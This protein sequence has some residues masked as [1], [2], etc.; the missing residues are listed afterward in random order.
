[1]QS[2][3]ERSGSGLPLHEFKCCAEVGM[4]CEQITFLT[5]RRR[6][7]VAPKGNLVKD[8]GKLWTGRKVCLNARSKDDEV[9][10][11]GANVGFDCRDACLRREPISMRNWHATRNFQ[12]CGNAK[13]YLGL[14]V[15]E[16]PP[17]CGA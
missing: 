4:S 7:S 16:A 10:C 9:K 14:A 12:I 17:E 15:P 8:R 11:E 3:E 2:T 13:R 1:M 5:G 6:E